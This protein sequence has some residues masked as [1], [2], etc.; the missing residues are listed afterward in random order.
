ME[1][2]FVTLKELSDLIN[3][4]KSNARKLILKYGISPQKRRTSDSRNQLTLTVTK[5]EADYVIEK[6]KEMGFLDSTRTVSNDIGVFYIIQLIPELDQKRIKLG[7]AE[8]VSAR[9]SQHRTSSPTSIVIKTWACKR[10]WE[11]TIID[12]L[13]F[14]NCKLILN[15]V[16]EC[17]DIKELIKIGDDLFAILPDPNIEIE[18][19]IHSPY[20]KIE[21]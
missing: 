8:D 9:L 17:E 20:Q 5:S 13:S 21:N 3:L 7:F 19:S 11:K 12:C 15:E 10:S 1:N 4:D 16:Y 18:K 2:D 14:R 6:R